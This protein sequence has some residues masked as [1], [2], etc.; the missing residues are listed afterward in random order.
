MITDTSEALNRLAREQL[1]LTILNDIRMDINVC[2][3]EGWDYKEYLNELIDLI[4]QFK[5]E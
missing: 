4:S 1:K 5:K 3:L 2:K